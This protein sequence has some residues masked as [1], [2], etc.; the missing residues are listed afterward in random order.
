MINGHGNDLQGLKRQLKADLSTNVFD[1]PKTSDLLAYLA[2]Q[3]ESV[4]NYPDSN[5]WALREQLAAYYRLSP[6]QILVT[7]GSTEAFYLLAHA[8][9]NSQ[10]TIR[11]P[12]FAEYDDACLLHQH[13]IRYIKNL[14]ELNGETENGLVWIGNPN[15]P[16]GRYLSPEHLTPRLEQHP[17]RLFVVDEAYIDLCES[18]ETMAPLVGRFPNLV[19]IKS[20][21]KLFAIPGI[22][23][24]YLLANPELIVRL[25][26]HHMPWAVNA[27][28]LKAGEYILNQPTLK[29]DAVRERLQ[30][31]KRLQQKLAGIAGLRVSP[32]PTNYFLCQLANGK[33]AALKKVLI[34]QHG[35]LIRDASNF[36]GLDTS[37][38]RIAA[39]TKTINNEFIHALKSGLNAI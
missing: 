30:E 27:L 15:N 31:S 39:Q 3:L 24:G 17:Q 20:F 7:N 32:S 14:D 13:Q 23:I 38:F 6:G 12:A 34:E 35:F 33:A 8:F 21:T 11:I 37:W 36:R 16:D 29:T 25:R 10:S 19:V 28:A 9:R 1:N 18:A 4:R 26:N 2:T 5:C 22:R